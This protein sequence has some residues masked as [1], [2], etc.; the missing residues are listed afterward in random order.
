M[1]IQEFH[2]GHRDD[3]SKISKVPIQLLGFILK[4]L[5]SVKNFSDN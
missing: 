5:V 4:I 1:P 2:T 3:L